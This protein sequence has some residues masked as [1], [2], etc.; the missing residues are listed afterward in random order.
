[1]AGFKVAQKPTGVATGARDLFA[2][3][4][5]L[6]FSTFQPFE[7]LPVKALVF[8]WWTLHGEITQLSDKDKANS[9]EF[10]EALVTFTFT[11]KQYNCQ[12]D[13]VSEGAPQRHMTYDNLHIHQSHPPTKPPNHLNRPQIDPNNEQ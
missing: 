10:Q 7:V 9:S 13:H 5:A 12:A 6:R 8:S 1:M 4:T 11:V 3:H 2:T